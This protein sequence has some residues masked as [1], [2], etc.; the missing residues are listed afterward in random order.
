MSTQLV[1]TVGKTRIIIAVIGCVDCGVEKT[2]AWMVAFRQEIKIGSR[3]EH[4]TL[5]RCADCADKANTRTQSVAGAQ[6]QTEL[7][8][9]R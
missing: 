4:I 2:R 1:R 6:P 3:R 5:K 7:E 8:T 9:A